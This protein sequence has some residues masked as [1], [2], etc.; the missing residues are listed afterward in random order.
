MV[1]AVAGW[2]RFVLCLIAATAC[3]RAPQPA[4]KPTAVH[5]V[6]LYRKESV[7]GRVSSPAPLRTEWRFDGAAP[8]E[9]PEKGA[10]TRGWEAG[11]GVSALAIRDG[12]LVG[13]TTTAFPLL[14]LEWPGAVGNL[15]TIDS[16]EVR[17]RVSAGKTLGVDA[18]G[19]EKVDL[20]EVVDGA[21]LWPWD[22]TAPLSPGT[23]TRT[24]TLRPPRPVSAADFRHLLL[25]PTD[26]AGA[27]FAIESV[28][29]VPRRE[30]LASIPSGVGWQG[31]SQVYRETLVA[32]APEVLRFE[33]E[34]PPRALLDLGVGTPEH[35]PVEFVVRLAPAGKA[36]AGAAGA[37]VA[38]DAKTLLA[39]TVTTPHRWEPLTVDLGAHAGERV[40]LE[41]ALAAEARGTLGFWGSPV[42]RQRV[43]PIAMAASVTAASSASPAGAAESAA[44]STAP[45]PQGVILI[46]ADTLRRDHLGT[47]GYRR[48]TSPFLD[49][50]AR[51]GVRF[52]HCVS[53]ATWTKVATPSLL[54]SLYPAT[55]GVTDFSHR[56]PAAFTTLAEVFRGGGVATISLSSILFT[57]QFTNL[58]QGF[59]ELHEDM[60]LPDRN[61]SK[62]ARIYVDR[63]LPWLERHRDVPF[64][65]FLHVSD[66]HD[67]YQ[68]Y[69]P[70]DT[71][72][73]DPAGKAE[74]ERQNREVRK[75]IASPLLKA[76]GMP[77]RAELVAAGF[78]ADAY[79][80]YDR[81]WYDGSIRGMDAEIGRLVERL[82]ELGLDRKTLV[83]FVGDHG[84]EFLEHDRT[85]HGQTTY[86][87]L[88]NVPLIVWRPGAIPAGR[89]VTETVETVD[90]MPT[91]LAAVGLPTPKEAQGTSFSAL[92]VDGGASRWRPR[93]AFTEKNLT[94]EPVGAPPPMDTET[95]A[96]VED[97]WKLV[98]NT[99]RP[100][101]GPEH[102]LYDV[103]TDPFDQHDLAA[104][105]AE[106]V[107][108]LSQRLTAWRTKSVNARKPPEAATAS[109]SPEEVERLRSLGYLQ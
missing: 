99:V 100:R 109:L 40:A 11:P 32:R 69:P 101:G 91:I 77:D 92:L 22:M 34:V 98:H 87:E 83:V 75:H 54:A 2:P 88:A 25:R 102:E 19:A 29:V 48:P 61:S 37:K 68:P 105:H 7:R 89:V 27:E 15:D 57:G 67:P 9:A 70:Y 26:V 24:L 50:L 13:R 76:F 64:F 5:L 45:P 59:E 80:D 36:A 108:R 12:R 81:G 16:L 84:E 65:A 6:D 3:A 8:P 20:A 49:R 18:R 23:E 35:G 74:H 4:A 60:S 41:L 46:W 103:R 42:V 14:H 43:E 63:L 90:V 62:T 96:V 44:S 106:I 52:D 78:D 53:Q 97:G 82:R 1:R 31:L 33:L 38:A 94:F 72:W 58:H 79:V 93:P 47:Y 73:S 39:R 10:A 51:E 17:L 55:H 66:A 71:L 28:R 21:K 104:Q 107:A 56:L 86:G 95:F 30:H 85:F